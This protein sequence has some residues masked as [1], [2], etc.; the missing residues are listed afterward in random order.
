MTRT[1]LPDM[2]TCMSLTVAPGAAALIFDIDGTLANTMEIHF[3]AWNEALAPEGIEISSRYFYTD[4]GGIANRRIVEILNE[5]YGTTMD[6]DRIAE[7]KNNAFLRHLKDVK[8]IEPVANLARAMHGKLPL[9]LGTGEISSIARQVISAIG[10][11]D[12]FSVLVAADDVEQHKPHP[13]TFLT[14]ARQMGVEPEVCQV[15]EDSKNGIEAARRAG[16]M[17]TDVREYV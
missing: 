13:E 16:M 3:R 6:A 1:G 4:L 8:A 11:A 15:F 7:K 2:L 14:C 12:Y 5:R 10:L 17:V 9:S